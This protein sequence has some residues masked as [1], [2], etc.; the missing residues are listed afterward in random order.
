MGGR[1]A[2]VRQRNQRKNFSFLRFTLYFRIFLHRRE[3]SRRLS[4][5]VTDVWW[6]IKALNCCLLL[7]VPAKVNTPWLG[8]SPSLQKLVGFFF[9]SRGTNTFGRVSHSCRAERCFVTT[10][11]RSCKRSTQTRGGSSSPVPSF[12]DGVNK[13]PR[14]HLDGA[15][16]NWS[17]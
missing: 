8:C 14:V 5:P 3:N 10:A 7:H 15:K 9:K 2:R 17:P 4:L 1:R 6:N 13:V 11:E 16:V 12:R